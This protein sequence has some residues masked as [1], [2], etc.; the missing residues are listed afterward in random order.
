MWTHRQ[1]RFLQD[2]A[3]RKISPDERDTYNKERKKERKKE[4]MLIRHHE[5]YKWHNWK[6]LLLLYR[7]Q[8]FLLN[9]LSR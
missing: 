5:T 1:K 4:I 2:L 7:F 6:T 8:T 9:K 3:R